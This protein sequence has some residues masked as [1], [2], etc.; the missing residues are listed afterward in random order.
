MLSGFDLGRGPKSG[1][2]SPWVKS[3]GL[4]GLFCEIHGE[5]QKT[6]DNT[7]VLGVP[8]SIP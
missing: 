2:K 7:R 3:N 8:R 5:S 6:G 1:R 4:K